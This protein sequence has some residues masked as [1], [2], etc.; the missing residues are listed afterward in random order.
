[1]TQ[2]DMGQ[3]VKWGFGSISVTWMP[4]SHMRKYR[5]QV[6]PPKPAPTTTTWGWAWLDCVWAHPDAATRAREA[7][8]DLRNSLRLMLI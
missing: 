1:M 7:A 5:A 2:L 3:E 8:E 4:G 6:A